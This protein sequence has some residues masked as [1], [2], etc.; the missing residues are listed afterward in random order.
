MEKSIII[1]PIDQLNLDPYAQI[2]GRQNVRPYSSIP[3]PTHVQLPPTRQNS[4]INP[5]PS[6]KLSFD[7]F[8]SQF[9]K[10]L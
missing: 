3:S 8:E 10:K 9:K 2:Y 6:G 1:K 4:A 5:M 7:L